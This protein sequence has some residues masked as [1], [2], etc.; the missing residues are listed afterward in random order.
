MDRVELILRMAQNKAEQ[1]KEKTAE[2]NGIG[3]GYLA[4]VRE[5]LAMA[6][7]A[8][9]TL[10][11]QEQRFAHFDPNRR[12]TQAN[13]PP[14]ITEMRRPNVGEQKDGRAASQ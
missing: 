6:R 7:D 12:V 4:E 9:E 8:V 3:A 2:I 14:A 13:Q 10:E 11:R 1:G 5:L